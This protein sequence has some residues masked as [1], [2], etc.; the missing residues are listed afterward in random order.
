MSQLTRRNFVKTVGLAGLTSMLAACGNG[1]GSGSGSAAA[2]ETID[3]IGVCL[4]SEPDS[5]D[6]ALNSA[7]DGATLISHL[8]AGLAKWEK[9]G[10]EFKIV[11][12]CATE[13]SKGE[14]SGNGKLTY[15]YILRDGLKWSDG[16]DLTAND[17]VYSWN[18]AAGPA[19][20]GDYNYMFDQ[21]DGYD[22]MWESR[23]TGETKKNEETGEEEPVLEFVNPDAKLNV[24]AKDDKTLVVVASKSCEPYW[25]ELLAF[26]TFFPVREDV[27]KSDKWVTDPST[28]VSNGAY[29]MTAWDHNSVIS[30]EKNENYHN[31]DV[32][33]MKEIQ[34]F[35][36]D[37]ANNML[38]N[39]E[40]GTWQLI[41]DVPT[42]EIASLKEKYPDEFKVDGQLGTYYVNWNVN[43][44]ILPAGTNLTGA[45]AENARAEIR[46]AIA[47]L[48]DRNHIINDI[49][50]GGQVPAS[51]FVAMGMT[52]ADGSQFYENAG[53]KKKN[54]YIG[55]ID[56]ADESLEKNFAAAIET[57][58]KYY[59]Y[60]EKKKT[61]SDFPSLTYLYNTQESHKMI[62]E[63]L[64]A[65]LSGIGINVK[66]ENQEW[67]TFLNTRKN[68]DYGIA[69]NGWVADYNYPMTFLDMWTTQSGNNDVQ[70]GKDAHASLKAY[71][72]D[73]TD[74]GGDLKIENGT[75]A[76][77]Y[78]KLVDAIKAEADSKKAY[79]LMH[80]A[81]D[82]LMSTGCICPL[83]F[84]T[85]LYMVDKNLQG[86]FSIP[87][88]YKFFTYTTLKK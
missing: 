25:N 54:G 73:T 42:N 62:G 45:E 80:K 40:N 7:V 21:I 55:Y 35:L 48:F 51:S 46:K 44:E 26:P 88:G 87:L 37:D 50:Q 81:E 85:D 59:K 49:A 84:Y 67:N 2:G 58:K 18:R 3:S 83:Y 22:A 41:D 78:D 63:Y 53:D 30:V 61:F 33:T 43:L 75:W 8:F 27:V 32:V 4:A 1:G 12:D 70:F 68:G 47:L 28:Y 86:F 74:V 16:K 29:K 19:L 5:I 23:D 57:L 65:A 10:E 38:S 64:Q 71:S 56:V 77:T 79:A 69:R 60:D 72:V 13:L 36:S 82:L 14:D 24:T 15:T 11:P 76:E 52:D 20:S 31:A 66:L 9:D 17:I 34:F 6:P 39:F